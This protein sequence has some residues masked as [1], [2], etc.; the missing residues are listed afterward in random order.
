M[1]TTAINPFDAVIV[2]VTLV[3]VV[4]GFNSGLL[5]S[6]ATIFGYFLAAPIAVMATPPLSRL[7][8]QFFHLPPTQAWIEFCAVF[9]AAGMVLGW[10][11]RMAVTEVT[12]RAVNLPDRAAGAMLGAVRVVLLAV[13]VVLV[14]DRIIPPG[15]EPAFLR[16]SQIRPILSEAARA[17]LRK[18]PPEIADNID[19]LKSERGI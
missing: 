3:A 18:L 10:M 6:L 4:M 15:H 2:L 12:G 8:T 13:L 14:F 16:G 19:R 5:R 7:L 17:G 1:G 9:I 11:C